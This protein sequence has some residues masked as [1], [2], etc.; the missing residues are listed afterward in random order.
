ME[1]ITQA[2]YESMEKKLYPVY[3]ESNVYIT[4]EIIQKM[5]KRGGIMD[6]ISDLAMW[7]KAFVHASY[8]AAQ[9]ERDPVKNE[10]FYGVLNA[11]DLVKNPQMMPLQPDSSESFEWLGDGILQAIMAHYLYNRY[12]NQQEGFLT[13]LRSK[14]VKTESLSK[15]ALALRF[16]KFLI[17]SKHIEIVCNGRKNNTI[18][19]DAFEGFIGAMMCDFGRTNRAQGFDKC[20][21]FIVNMMEQYIDITQLII[22]DD[23]YKDQLMRY[24]HKNFGGK[25]P[26]Y[27]LKE[28]INVQGENQIVTKRFHMVVYDLDGKLIGSG[29]QKNKQDAEQQAARE[30]LKQYGITHAYLL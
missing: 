8:S 23:N 10:K 20:Y 28:V 1:V 21:T 16:D 26:R 13:K 5:L 3:N 4:K 19:E 29:I 2:Q 30:A 6:E 12:P 24:F 14:L 11:E 27:E 9:W 18:L 17:I 7:Q 15:L 22:H 25:L